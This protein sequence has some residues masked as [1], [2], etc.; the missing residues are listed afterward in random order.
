MLRR[1]WR[2]VFFGGVALGLLAVL[3][4]AVGYA[5]LSKDLPSLE[6]IRAY[7]P[8]QS[9]FVYDRDG[10]LV[11][12]FFEERRRTLPLAQMP[13]ACLLAVLAAEDADFFRHGGFDVLGIARAVLARLR[14][15]RLQGASTLT[16]QVVKVLLLSPERTLRR[17][18]RELILARRV[19][20]ALTKEEI[21]A[22]YLNQVNFGHGR[23]GL[24]EAARYY[25]AKKAPQLSLAE[26]AL[27][28]GLPQSPTRLSPRRYPQAALKRRAYVLAQLEAKAPT[29]WPDLDPEA[30]QRA[31]SAALDL[32][33]PAV[34]PAG[35]QQLV[36]ELRRRLASELGPQ[37][38]RR[39][40]LSIH[41]GLDLRL[42]AKVQRAG[43]RAMRAVDA[44]LW[45]RGRSQ[46]PSAPMRG[47]L[48]QSATDKVLRLRVGDTTRVI[49]RV[50]SPRYAALW[51]KLAALP[52]GTTLPVR[53]QG[54]DLQLALGPEL[55]VV[56][57]DAKTGELR[58]LLGGYADGV[59]FNRATQARR[60]P[61]SAFK[62]LAYALALTGRTHTL[63]SKLF[64]APT[65]YAAWQP[66]NYEPWRFQGE[67]GFRQAIARSVNLAAVR[68]ADALGPE[69]LV[70]FAARL[71]IEEPLAANL[72]LVLGAGE[73]AP[74]SL[75]AAYSVFASGGLRFDA[76]LITR[77]ER[78]SGA[79]L[80]RDTPRR[81]RVFSEAEAFLVTSLMRSVVLEGTG[82]S[83]QRL[84]FE[85]AGKTGTSNKARDAWFVGYSTAYVVG[86]WVGYDDRRV[87]GRGEGGSRTALPVWVAV[88][89]ALHEDAPEPFRAPAGLL[90]L[91]I[92]AAGQRVASGATAAREEW[93]LPGTEPAPADALGEL[94]P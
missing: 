71:G 24:S 63:A 55:A 80:G 83:A 78:P 26:C 34:Q 41:T 68:L 25:F 59:G 40:G 91:P 89:E 48:L 47:A 19:E 10:A 77:I 20:A 62:P 23:Y 17:K 27:L 37:T 88:M 12:S 38:L 54:K 18:L 2:V 74:L 6:A 8:P 45:R 66:S 31:K 81:R 21:L 94:P 15:R 3:A 58:A 51:P 57:L 28:A 72:A 93:F 90:R 13:R 39:G 22:L 76:P 64:D 70:R 9:S 36:A 46:R 49:R 14:G 87:L 86:V 69:S 33:A 75:T 84:G 52:A 82:R 50:D 4:V 42:Q 7:A 35:A 44:R 29:H 67:I 65:R 30:L 1:L 79:P 85:V 32:V 61:G 16:Q 92:D 60:Q 53:A 5:Q 11:G 43:Q 56:V 73:L